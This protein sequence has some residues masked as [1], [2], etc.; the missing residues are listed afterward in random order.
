MLWLNKGFVILFFLGLMVMSVSCEKTPGT[1]KDNLV[2]NSQLL[3]GDFEE[4][5]GSGK[6]IEPCHWNSFMSASGSGMAYSAGR[7]QQV[8]VSNETRPGSI[9]SKSACIFTRS[10]L[11]VIANGNL[12]T[13]QINIGGVS[14]TS[15]KNYNIS[16]ANNADYHQVITSKP[17]SI[18][19]W[20]KFKC[21]DASQCARMSATIHDSCDYRDPETSADAVHVVGKAYC[22]FTARQGEWIWHTVPFDYGYP[23]QTPKYIL[24]TFT[25]NKVP[26]SGNNNDTLWVDDVELIYNK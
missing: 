3:N 15:S 13:G 20:S 23:S 21:V 14:A 4:W 16:R 26:G 22:E 2:E 19:F 24:I 25:T 17:D 10:I 11:G 18:R 9:G 8:D 6:E 7:G 1:K 12:T 5:E